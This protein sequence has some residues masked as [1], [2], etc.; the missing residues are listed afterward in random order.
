MPGISAALLPGAPGALRQALPQLDLS[1]PLWLRHQ[2]DWDAYAL[3]CFLP[4]TSAMFSP[5]RRPGLP[6]GETPWKTPER[7]LEGASQKE[8]E[9]VKKKSVN[10]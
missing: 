4:A 8:V 2:A 6:E 9:K 3:T 1:Q 5:R 10:C 7:T